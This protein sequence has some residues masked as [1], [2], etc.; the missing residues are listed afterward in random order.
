MWQEQIRE[1]LSTF[2]KSQPESPS[3][4]NLSL[5]PSQTAENHLS[6]WFPCLLK[7]LFSY[8]G[9]TFFPIMYLFLFVSE[10][11]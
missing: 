6:I 2:L 3:D 5:A 9:G 8:L 7:E 11:T 4:F 1:I 10:Y